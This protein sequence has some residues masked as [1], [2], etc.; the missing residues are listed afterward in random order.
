MDNEMVI[1]GLAYAS[2]EMQDTL[3]GLPPGTAAAIRRNPAQH[4]V[5]KKSIKNLTVPKAAI[6]SGIHSTYRDEVLRRLDGLP[7]KIVNGLMKKE[8]QLNDVNY[9]VVKSFAAT[10]TVG[11]IFV[12]A[13]VKKAGVANVNFRKLA[14]DMWFMP[15][16]IQVLAAEDT[17]SALGDPLVQSI[18]PYQVAFPEIL[19]GNCELKN[20]TKYFLNEDTGCEIFDTTTRTDVMPGTY[21]LNNPKWCEPETDL[22]FNMKFG[23]GG[24]QQATAIRV[25]LYGAVV[26][27]R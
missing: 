4:K 7:E 2:P 1:A 24:L 23:V 10:A 22:Q 11:E 21:R 12:D 19:N 25:G 15:I 9:Y 14:K 13:D 5:F 16:H 26:S 17:G 6:P 8:L 27:I 18:L 20:N 3:L